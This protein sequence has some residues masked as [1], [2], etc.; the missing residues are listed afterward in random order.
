MKVA[1]NMDS[2]FANCTSDELDFDLMFD[3]DD[4]LIDAVA[5]V[6]E[7]GIPWTGPDPESEYQL[8]GDASYSEKDAEGSKDVSLPVSGE[9]GTTGMFKGKSAE[10]QAHDVTPGIKKAIEEGFDLDDLFTESDDQNQNDNNSSSPSNDGD[11]SQ[12]DDHNVNNN[13]DQNNGNNNQNNNNNNVKEDYRMGSFYDDDSI[14]ESIIASATGYDAVDEAVN[15]LCEGSVAIDE[16][17]EASTESLEEK[18][19]EKTLLDEGAKDKLVDFYTKTGVKRDENGNVAKYVT[20]PNG[21]R[22]AATAGA[23]A[24][25]VGTGIAIKKH[26]DKKKSQKDSQDSQ[27]EAAE[28][29]FYDA[30]AVDEGVKEKVKGACSKADGTISKGKVAGAEL[31]AAA[32]TGAGVAA[33]KGIKAHNKKKSE[34]AQNESYYLQIGDADIACGESA[35]CDTD[36]VIT[37]SLKE[38]YD[39]F[40]AAERAKHIEEIAMESYLVAEAKNDGKPSLISKATNGVKNA[41][42]KEKTVAQRDNDGNVTKYIAK[43]VPNAKGVAAAAVGAAALTGAGIAAKKAYDKKKAQGKCDQQTNESVVYYSAYETYYDEAADCLTVAVYPPT[44]KLEGAKLGLAGEVIPV[45][46]STCYGYENNYMDSFNESVDAFDEEY[47]FVLDEDANKNILSNLKPSEIKKAIKAASETA[48]EY[49]GAH[50][51][52]RKAAIA[53]AFAAAVGGGALVGHV[54]TK[55][56]YEKSQAQNESYDELDDIIESVLA[57]NGIKDKLAGAGDKAHT[58]ALKIPGINK[59]VDAIDKYVQKCKDE[60]KAN[61]PKIIAGAIAAALAVIGVTGI[62]LHGKKK[63]NQHDNDQD[64]TNEAV[65]AALEAFADPF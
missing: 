43:R 57:E 59:I 22:I 54:V 63:A 10:S 24:A 4:S 21:K 61:K 30:T 64:A 7:A 47:V 58:Q 45:D 48:V 35:L 13:N 44:A 19:L 18:V 17:F 16:A 65:D 46:E 49:M 60:G 38:G 34:K 29:G 20:A 23:A 51:N 40:R 9:V 39:A 55:K 5:G 56:K 32:L 37:G 15:T 11:I 25:A 62:V 1:K 41:L 52:V 26:L 50:P 36:T 53:G 2:V 8:D 12:N 14:A 33:V 28:F 27:Q 6:N 42:T 31:G 3:E